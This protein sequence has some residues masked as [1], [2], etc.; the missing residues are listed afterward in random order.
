[1]FLACQIMFYPY[2]ISMKNLYLKICNLELFIFENIFGCVVSGGQMI[3]LD[4]VYG[5]SL[6][7]STILSY[8]TKTVGFRTSKL[9]GISPENVTNQQ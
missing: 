4:V 6:E 8:N 9:M 3:C 5:A 2:L 7:R 1:M